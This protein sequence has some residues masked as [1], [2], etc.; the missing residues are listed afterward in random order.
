VGGSSK[1][2]KIM[3]VVRKYFRIPKEQTQ[4]QKLK[5]AKRIVAGSKKLKP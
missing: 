2:V 4:K 1:P 5:V 3:D